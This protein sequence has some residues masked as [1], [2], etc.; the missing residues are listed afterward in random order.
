MKQRRSIRL[1]AGVMA[2]GLVVAACGGDDDDT[3]ADSGDTPTAEETADS[4][5]MTEDS[6]DM[7]ED[8][9]DMSEDSGD[10]SED[11]GDMSEDSGDMSEDSGDMSEDSGDMSEDA[12]GVDLSG[13]CP[14]PIVI[15]TDWF[16]EAEHGS[17][18]EMVGE[19][20]EI[21]AELMTVTGP[22]MASGVDTG[23]E[24]EVRTGGPAIGFN[25]PRVNA[26]TDDSIHL[27]YSSFDAQAAAWA[28]LPMVTVL[29][30]LEINPQ[31]IMW[32]AD[33]WPDVDTIA[34]VGEAGMTINVFGGGGFAPYFVA[35]GIWDESQVDPSYDGSPA[36]FIAEGNIAQQGFASAEPYNYENVFEEYGKAPKYQLLH[37]AGYQSY[38][39]TLAVKPADV[40]ALAPCLEL[41]VPI[42]QQAVVDFANA[43]ERANAIIIDAVATFDSFWVYDEGVAAYAVETM[44]ELGLHGNGP[45][46]IVGNIDEARVQKVIDDARLAG[47]DVP[48]DLVAADM[49]TNE[50]VDESIGF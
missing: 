9:G 14:S 49:F 45:D 32:D 34:D 48:D 12:A 47:V 1:V 13:V 17:L 27:A 29:A 26:Y 24:I 46:D 6:G 50:F 23:V 11:S 36:R 3:P 39:Q 25:S 40:E 38:S 15:Q 44:T 31:I 42:V 30:P 41:F 18:Y 16:P 35:A 10:M 28:D 19:G 2:L 5:D 7:T 33:E 8:S 4:G 22:L 21:N 37:D 43:P 20:Y